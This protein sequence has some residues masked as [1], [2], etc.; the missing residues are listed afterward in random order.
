M[1]RRIAPAAALV[2]G[3]LLAVSG[4]IGM[5]A[6]PTRASCAFMSL[7]PPVRDGQ[8]LFVATVTQAFE[9]SAIVSVERWLA[10]P[11]QAGDILVRGRWSD[12]PDISSSVDWEPVLG[13]TEVIRATPDALGVLRTNLCSTSPLTAEALAAIEAT[14]GPP[15]SPVASA[16]PAASPSAQPDASVSP[17]PASAAPSA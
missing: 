2:S 1:R 9:S 11:V 14:Y 13:Q 12:D 17:G 3:L 10:G 7:I 5:P 8:V 6:A 4:V 16:S 15:P